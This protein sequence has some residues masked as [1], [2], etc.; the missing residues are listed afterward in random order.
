MALTSPLHPYQAEPVERFAAR[1]NLLLAYGTGTGKT[2]IAL[3]AAERLLDAG[4]VS[5][6]LVVC[7]ASLKYQWARRIAE[8]TRLP[9]REARVR[10]KTLTLPAEPECTVIDGGPDARARQYAA[11]RGS[12]EYVICGYDNVTSEHRKIRL[13]HAG[14]V[15]IDEAS[16]IKSLTA[17]RSRAVKQHLGRAP[18][19][20]AL[21]ATPV[22]NRLEELYSIMEFVDPEILGRYDLFD[23]SFIVR[24]RYGRVERYKHLDVVHQKIAPAMCRL[25][26][27]DPEVAAYLPGVTRAT[28]TVEP[29]PG[30]WTA[31]LAMARDLLDAYD[32]A[33]PPPGFSLDAHYGRAPDASVPSGMGKLM[34]I[35]GCMEMLLCHPELV[36]ASAD[37][38]RSGGSRGSAYASAAVGAGL[39]DGLPAPKLERLLDR[40]APVL[41]RGDKIAVYTRYREMLPILEREL[42][43]LGY[44]SVLYHGG[45]T[46]GEKDAAVAAFAARGQVLLSSHAGAYGVD[47]PMARYLVNY[48]VPWGAGT[49]DQIN[50]RH[51][52]ASSTFARV[53]VRDMVTAG[54][55]EERK[56]D[57]QAFKRRIS[58]GAV[59][60]HRAAA[61]IGNDTGTLI[62]HLTGLF[63]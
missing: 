56:V 8:F 53:H 7:P 39:L 11:A 16:A 1:G 38:F 9:R 6:V 22:E 35:H 3:A 33:P 54:T 10:G 40:C 21:T 59:D 58:S 34:A 25:T 50:G 2:V 19:R 28:W 62:D 31:Y 46:P 61:A 51:V 18:W 36:R 48:D 42:T 26:R 44:P 12:A 24:D 37:A 23:K 63:P 47:L 17:A 5:T 45:M 27:A 15:I 41:A 49:A 4:E 29:D 30:T 57:G 55:I 32:D 43:D 52:R 20:M 14:M 13:L 60:G